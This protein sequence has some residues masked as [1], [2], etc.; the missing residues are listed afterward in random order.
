MPLFRPAFATLALLATSLAAAELPEGVLTRLRAA[1]IPAEAMGA[2][3]IR[4]SDGAVATSHEPERALQPAST[5]KPLTAIVALEKLGPAYRGRTELRVRGE[6]A[7]ERLQG[8]LFLRGLGNVDFDWRALER[9][10][11]VA[12]QKG[13]REI[14]GDVLLDLS[15]FRPARPDVGLAPF[16]EAPEFRYNVV[17]DALMLNT[18]LLQVDLHADA[19]SVRAFLTP[20]IE[21]VSIVSE[22]KIAER[23]C[24]DW[25]DGWIIPEV[26]RQGRG[27]LSIKL[28]GDF[29]RDCSASTSINVID[30][31]A[32]ADRLFRMLWRRMG[33]TFN[34]RVREGETP[35]DARLVAQHQSRTL[36]ELMRD[37][38]KRSDNPITRVLYLTLG[39]LADAPGDEPTARKADREVRAWLE[40]KGIDARGLVLENGSGLSRSE[41]I[42]AAQRAAVLKAALASEWAPEFLAGFPIVAVDG[43]MRSRLRDGPAAGRARIKTGTLRDST[44][45]AGYMR[46]AAGEQH[47][48]VAI[49]NHANAKRQVAR[50]IGDA[51]L[52]WFSRRAPAPSAAPAQRAP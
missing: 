12:R 39:A 36:A 44:A 23:A 29:P 1:G 2:I 21:K 49:V 9:L 43:G 18:N 8:D 22:M 25:E 20:E 35:A 41:R 27:G 37:V 3:A 40:R 42:S 51:W 52:D 48:V 28:R 45:V 10:L 14:D 15:F 13:I 34:G 38:N 6:I 33:G 17:P 32:F 16:D 5:L 31:G 26:A 4:V 7:G 50:P 11:Q 46:D 47:V 19:R 30:R 24:E